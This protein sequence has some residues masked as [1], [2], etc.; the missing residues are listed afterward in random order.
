MVLFE[1]S[2]FL[3][4]TN[5]RSIEITEE[6]VIAALHSPSL[7][8]WCL[9]SDR[10]H[11]AISNL[12]FRQYEVQELERLLAFA[13]DGDTFFDIG[14]N[15]GLY[16]IAFAQKCPNSTIC[17][18]EPIRT[19]WDEL[20]RNIL[21]NGVS[22]KTYNIGLGEGKGRADFYFDKAATGATSG[23][24]LGAGFET[25]IVTGSVEPLD[26]FIHLKPSILKCDVEGAE[27]MVFKGGAKTI[28]TCLPV[29]QC[30]M[31]R[32]WAKR[33]NYHPNQII[34]FMEALGYKCFSLEN[35]RLV[36]FSEMTEETVQTNFYFLHTEK[37]QNFISTGS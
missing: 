18:F 31:L 5:I 14:A 8:L 32:K 26:A 13:R 7:R 34:A 29:I 11:V 3:K 17:A 30:E 6:G 33:F 19:T 27:L 23:A 25:E 22:V 1:Y 16:S 12:N 35:D 2:R 37:H 20:N 10:G 9:P 4:G 24:P 15:V 21:L 36:Y 28:E